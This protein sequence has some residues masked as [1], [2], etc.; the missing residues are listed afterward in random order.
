[1]DVITDDWSKNDFN[2]LQWIND[3]LAAKKEDISEVR[4]QTLKF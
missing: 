2:S 4:D 1:M 3:V